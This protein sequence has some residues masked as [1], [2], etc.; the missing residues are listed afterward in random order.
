MNQRARQTTLRL[1][2]W[3]ARYWAEAILANV[4]SDVLRSPVYAPLGRHGGFEQPRAE[5]SVYT[6][7]RSEGFDKYRKGQS[8][9]TTYPESEKAKL[10][11]TGQ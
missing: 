1:P 11:D 4:A 9:T 2:A 8:T 10:S 3:Q 5:T 6:A 7:R